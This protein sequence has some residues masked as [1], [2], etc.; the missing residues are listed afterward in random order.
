MGNEQEKEEKMNSVY[1]EQLKIFTEKKVITYIR[2]SYNLPTI[3]NI[4]N[5]FNHLI[6]F[7]G[8]V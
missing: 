5:S 3:I 4:N 8:L 6:P 2:I 1:E 7:F